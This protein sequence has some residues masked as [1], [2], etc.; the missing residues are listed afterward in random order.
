MLKKDKKLV[1]LV[2]IILVFASA[3]ITVYFCGDYW[4]NEFLRTQYMQEKLWP[5]VS[6]LV[7]KYAF[8]DLS[9]ETYKKY[10]TQHFTIYYKTQDKDLVQTVVRAAEKIYQPVSDKMRYT[11]QEKTPIVIIP[12]TENSDYNQFAGLIRVTEKI[13]NEGEFTPEV[14][15]SHEFTHIL[16]RDLT[17]DNMLSWLNEGIAVYVESSISGRKPYDLSREDLQYTY[18][19]QELEDNFGQIPSNQSYCQGYLTV[20]YIVSHYGEDTLFKIIHEL[21]DDRIKEETLFKKY[22]GMDYNALYDKVVQYKQE[23]IVSK[24]I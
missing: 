1:S 10:E 16:I 7:N 15:L 11:R 19:V 4:F 3:G 23:L 21:K 20:K 24:N 14:I 17:R 13:V 2:L 8:H 22:L 12:D 9:I 18:K 5:R 6:F